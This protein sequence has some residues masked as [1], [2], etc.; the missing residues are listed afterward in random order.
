MRVILG[1]FNTENIA[2]G[3]TP[4]RLVGVAATRPTTARLALLLTAGG[5]LFVG[6]ANVTITNG[7]AVAAGGELSFDAVDGLWAVAATNTTCHLFE[8]F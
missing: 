6:G 5:D 4:V 7:K 3:T 8:G 1:A 2:V